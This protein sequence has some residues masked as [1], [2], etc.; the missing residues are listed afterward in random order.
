MGDNAAARNQSILD[1]ISLIFDAGEKL[2]CVFVRSYDTHNVL[3]LKNKVTVG[4]IRLIP[5]LNRADNDVRAIFHR[6]FSNGHTDKLALLRQTEL[7]KLHLAF[8]KRLDLNGGRETQHARNFFR[9]RIFGVDDHRQTKLVLQ[10]RNLAA[11][12]GAF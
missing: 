9:R 5:S 7:D 1:C 4:D 3:F 6:H 10:I 2:V 12:F 8:R 11:V